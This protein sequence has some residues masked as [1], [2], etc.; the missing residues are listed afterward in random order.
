M[1]RSPLIHQMSLVTLKL[2]M[3]ESAESLV[4]GKSA[5]SLSV[6]LLSVV[7]AAAESTAKQS[8]PF[9]RSLLTVPCSYSPQCM[10]MLYILVVSRWYDSIFNAKL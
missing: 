7:S 5:D 10:Y 8:Q 3:S 2:N 9:A 4:I 1:I 6:R